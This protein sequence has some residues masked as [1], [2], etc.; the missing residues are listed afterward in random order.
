[1]ATFDA[2]P[3]IAAGDEPFGQIM[4]AADALA[5]DEDL[6]V[7]APFEPVPLVSVLASRGFTCEATEI[8]EGDWRV[9]FTR[10]TATTQ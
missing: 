5:P 3:V 8:A 7:L 4:A 6:I 1:M 10:A 2:R 9:T